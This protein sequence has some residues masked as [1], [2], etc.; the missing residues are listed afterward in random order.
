MHLNVL[1][2]WGSGLFLFGICLLLLDF[3]LQ[4]ACHVPCSAGFGVLQAQLVPPKIQPPFLPPSP[5]AFVPLQQA[6][7]CCSRRTLLF[8]MALGW[9]QSFLPLTHKNPQSPCPPAQQHAHHLP[10]FCKKS[11]IFVSPGKQN[12]VARRCT[13]KGAGVQT[14]RTKGLANVRT[15]GEQR[16]KLRHVYKVLQ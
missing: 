6:V 1:R 12:G 11:N 2:F 5:L 16:Q 9:L 7:K 14:H 13:N 3:V 10:C 4:H 15:E 8:N